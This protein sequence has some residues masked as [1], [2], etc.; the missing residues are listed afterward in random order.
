MTK[1]TPEQQ[2][3]HAVDHGVARSG[4]P[5]D[6]RRTLPARTKPAGRAACESMRTS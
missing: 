5:E 4:L 2:A 3:A 1:M 6:A